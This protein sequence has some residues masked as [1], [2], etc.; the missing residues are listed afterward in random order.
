MDETKNVTRLN[1]QNHLV[2]RGLAF[3]LLLERGLDL[4]DVKMSEIFREGVPF[5]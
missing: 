1:S 3:D 5:D 2:G 4:S